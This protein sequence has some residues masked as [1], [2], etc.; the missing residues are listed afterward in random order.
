MKRIL[1][2]ILTIISGALHAQTDSTSEKISINIAGTFSKFQQ[3]VKSDVGT[4][5]GERLVDEQQ[6][7]YL[8]SSVYKPSKYFGFGF[9][10]RHDIGKRE[11]AIFTGFDANGAA[12][13]E[14]E[15]GGDY[16]EIWMGPLASF[17]WKQIMLD[18]GFGAYG[19]RKDAGRDDLPSKSGSTSG[20]FTTHP[21]IAWLASI[22][23]NIPICENFDMSFRAEYRVRY[24]TQ[25]SGED[26]L[27]GVEHGTQSFAPVIGIV[28]KM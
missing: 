27:E 13:T 8:I 21:T 7:G 12:I 24:Y 17:F 26:I 23:G 25:R 10:F 16:N 22:G 4:I 15:L 14:Q 18:I 28:W 11:A 19:S 2:I 20:S 9:Y 1:T 3:Q 5:S 6:F